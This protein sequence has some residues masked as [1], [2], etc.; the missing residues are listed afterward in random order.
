MKAFFM[1]VNRETWQSYISY[2]PNANVAVFLRISQLFTGN[3]PLPIQLY[4]MKQTV[5]A[6]K[7]NSYKFSIK[8]HEKDNPIYFFFDKFNPPTQSS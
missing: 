8:E 2:A 1:R 5:I 3:R 4:Q 7:N 6:C